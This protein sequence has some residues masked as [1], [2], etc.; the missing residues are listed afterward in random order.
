MQL[1]QYIIPEVR[2]VSRPAAFALHLATQELAVLLMST[3]PDEDE[4]DE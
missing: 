1:I 2:D 3:N 4:Q